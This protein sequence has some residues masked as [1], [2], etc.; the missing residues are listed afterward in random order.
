MK[1]TKI[2]NLKISKALKGKS[3]SLIHR[4]RIGEE[5]KIR[6]SD[7]TLNPNYK[8]DSVGYIGIHIWLRKKYGL[9]HHCDKCGSIGRKNNNKWTISYALKKGSIYERKRSNFIRLCN[10]DHRE[11]DKTKKWGE[12]IS[13]AKKGIKRVTNFSR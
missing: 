6:L 5:A 11:Y 9:A 3:K 13:K 8:G 4:K 10:K 12:N 2:H 7:P 1:R